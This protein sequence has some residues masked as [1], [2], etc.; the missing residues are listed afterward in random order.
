[1]GKAPAHVEP[2]YVRS[3]NPI[4]YDDAEG[5]GMRFEAAVQAIA[6]GGTM[7]VTPRELRIEGAHAVTFLVAAATGFRGFD[8]APDRTADEIA[9]D[10]RA[11][12][13]AAS[14]K[15]LRRLARR[16]HR[17][18]SEALPPRYA[19]SAQDRRRRIADQ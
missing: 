16:A 15:G 18:S 1:M 7:R 4:V 5:K 19:E 12:L 10:C 14:K 11:R 3:P 13:D 9:A 6:E 2:N 17:R 8:H